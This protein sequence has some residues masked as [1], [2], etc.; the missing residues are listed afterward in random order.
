MLE[1]LDAIEREVLMAAPA[2]RV[3]QFLTDPE[4]LPRWY[5]GARLEPRVGAVATFDCGAAAPYLGVVDTVDPPRQ[6]AWRWCLEA[7]LPVGEG[8][9][10]RVEIALL[11]AGDKTRVRLVES[12]FAALSPDVRA[13]CQPGNDAGWE[14]LLTSLAGQVAAPER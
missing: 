10:T 7:G 11:P 6:L 1:V 14:M 4:H 12:G 3:W 9:T 5:P 13:R 2:E 8:P